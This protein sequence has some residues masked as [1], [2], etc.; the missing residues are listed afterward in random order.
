MFELVRGVYVVG[1]DAR[2][3]NQAIRVLRDIR[4]HILVG[5]V[6]AEYAGAEGNYHGE[7]AV[8][9][10]R[11][12]GSEGDVYR[13]GAGRGRFRLRFGGPVGLLGDVPAARAR[14]RELERDLLGQMLRLQPHVRMRVYDHPLDSPAR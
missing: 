10:V 13:F 12:M 5:Y 6:D 3:T 1:I 4:C 9:R 14:G 7:V 8:L 11:P 2:K